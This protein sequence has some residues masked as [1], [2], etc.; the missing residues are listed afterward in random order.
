MQTCTPFPKP[1]Y[2]KHKALRNPV[3]TADSICRYC[4]RTYASLHEIYAGTGRRQ[5]CIKYKLQVPLCIYCHK[6]IQEH[7]MSGRDLEL[8]KEFQAKFEQ[9]YGHEKF[10]E[11]FRKNYL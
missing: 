9:E 3:P 11:L 5:L 1:Q 6:D 2:K 4:G 7:P 10:I 8:K